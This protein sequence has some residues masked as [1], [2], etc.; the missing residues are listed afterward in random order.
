M[1][2]G[3]ERFKA[4]AEKISESFPELK[5]EELESK[6]PQIS[7]KLVLRD[8]DGL[9]I[10][11]YN[12]RIEP[13]ESY[14]LKFPKVY[15]TGGR[16]PLNIDWHVFPDGHCCIKSIPEE[17]LICNNGINLKKFINDQVIPY[18]FNQKY[19]EM[20]GFF[21]KERAHG[22]D[23]NIAFF[24][25]VFNTRDL[26]KIARAL[27]FI[28]ARKEPGR[29]SQCFC[30]EKIKYRKC[31]RKEFKLLQ[32]FSDEDFDKYLNMI[33]SSPRFKMNNL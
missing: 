7:G 28:K 19:R 4:E 2:K 18:F 14:P 26:T 24:E 20:H 8:Q 3:F 23:G 13:H 27:I 21:L 30:G 15:E 5:F 11:S 12:I 17:N 33:V 22:R 32:V 6:A 29:T 31:H 1:N 16:I 9:C 25:D 10:D